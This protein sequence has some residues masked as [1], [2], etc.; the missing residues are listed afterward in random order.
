MRCSEIL[1][2][3]ILGGSI[4]LSGCAM[5]SPLKSS[6]PEARKA[7]VAAIT[8]EK[9]LFFVAMNV[10]VTLPDG[11]LIEQ[12]M[13]TKEDYP[14]DVR[15]M[16]AKKI[17][18]PSYLVCC[19][20][21][22]DGWVYT[23]DRLEFKGRSYYNS[24][25]EYAFWQPVAPGDAVRAA[26]KEKIGNLDVLKKVALLLKADGDYDAKAMEGIFPSHV[27]KVEG[28]RTYYLEFGDGYGDK[29]PHP[30]MDTHRHILPGNP[31]DV[32][33]T[34]IIGK[35]GLPEA[36]VLVFNGA[37]GAQF[38]TPVAY[39]MAMMK[40]AGVNSKVA[41]A[42]FR[43]IF[44]K[45]GK[46][47]HG[48]PSDYSTLLYGC[49]VNP[50]KDIVTA[51]LGFCERDK[52][53]RP[54]LMKQNG[55][56]RKRG[57][58]SSA[59]SSK[60]DWDISDMKDVFARVTTPSVFAEVLIS[61][62]LQSAIGRLNKEQ[63]CAIGCPFDKSWFDFKPSD[64]DG[65]LKNLKDNETLKVL[66]Q[67]ASLYSIRLAAIKKITNGKI[68]SELVEKDFRKCPY[69]TSM[70]DYDPFATA[71]GVGKG[72]FDWINATEQNSARRLREAAVLAITD[73]A[74][75][76]DLRRKNPDRIFNR[77]ITKRIHENGGSDVNDIIACQ[78]YDD[79]LFIMLE[80]ETDMAAN[81][82]ISSSATLKGIRLMAAEKLP[83]QELADIV[84][85][86]VLTVQGECPERHVAIGKFHLG[87]G[88]EDMFA[89]VLSM[90][91]A[92]RPELYIDGKAL[93]LRERL[94]RDIAWANN[95]GN[96]PAHWL[97]LPPEVVKVV[98]GFKG[99]TFDDLYRAVCKTLNA[100]FGYDK[101]RKGEVSQD[102]GNI[103]TADG[104]TLR[105]FRS[106]I[107]EGEDFSRSVRKRMNQR[108]MDETPDQGGFGALLS[109][110]AE[111]AQQHKENSKNANASCFA[112]QGAL[113]LLATS[114]AT[115]GV[116]GA[117]GS[118]NFKGTS[119]KDSMDNL[120]SAV[121]ELNNLS[122]KLD[123]GL[124]DTA[125]KLKAATPKTPDETNLNDALK[126]LESAIDGL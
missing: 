105:F 91:P 75:L 6:D 60:G 30:Y 1:S 64:A 8:D 103:D 89:L 104:E 45:D 112:R 28:G 61:N 2:A 44:F 101:I 70:K 86:E 118:L 15:I 38:I 92:V 50:E 26:A 40:L 81:R 67:S 63:R 71:F 29:P 123:K 85:K 107:T 78:K 76:K 102:I 32:V 21:W 53:A 46:L 25:N 72:Q 113:Q 120:K 114:S 77:F 96:F 79:S 22:Q 47:Q 3:T 62:D 42:L 36:V 54:V 11:F 18:D 56:G 23:A 27:A 73:V 5:F 41:K 100:D 31:L 13:L 119:I 122:G 106:E 43:K 37:Y 125:E 90:A 16:A 55:D 121:K 99:G 66:A 14:D 84:Q 49:M 97:C 39:D 17:S 124:K 74:V 34:D 7:A 82:K 87:Q 94:G 98:V 65:V 10:G 68:L 12:G 59:S 83:E 69:D 126:Q 51:M 80:G 52:I 33:M 88:I 9:E 110:I 108:V 20:T 95:S 116:L 24:Q 48:I 115:K 58:A 35:K 111:D 117:G 4:L 19:A 109:N 57:N 93:C